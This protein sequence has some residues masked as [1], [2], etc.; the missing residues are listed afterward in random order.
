MIQEFKI[1]KIWFKAKS[2]LIATNIKIQIL[3]FWPTKQ[4]NFLK[5]YLIFF[6]I[7]FQNKITETHYHIVMKT[8]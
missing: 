2:Y 7:I 8:L 4:I 3:L 1:P 6:K 5:K